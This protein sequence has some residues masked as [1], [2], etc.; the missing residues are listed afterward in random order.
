MKFVKAA[1]VF[2]DWVEDTPKILQ[3]ALAH[4]LRNWKLHKITDDI[5]EQT[6]VIDVIHKYF[7]PIKNIFV[8]SSVESGTP[9]DISKRQFFLF[10]K[11]AKMINA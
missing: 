11:D 7:E 8:A 1:S 9:P 4:D 3:A 10:C 6:K 5:S 2:A